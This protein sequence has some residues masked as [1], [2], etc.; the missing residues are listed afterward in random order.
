MSKSREGLEGGLVSPHTPGG[1]DRSPSF[2]RRAKSFAKSACHPGSPKQRIPA[3]EWVP[4]YNLE[5]FQ[6][7]MVAGITV[8]LTVIPQG[9]AYATVAGV[10][11]NYGLYSSFMGCFVYFFFGT[12]KD[13]T[14]GPT[15]IMSIMTHQYITKG[16]ECYEEEGVAEAMAVLLSMITGVVILLATVLRVGFLINFIGRPVI[17]GFTSAAAI[18]IATSQVKSLFG[19]EFEAEGFIE[20]WAEV[21]RHLGETRYQDFLVGAVSCVVL[22]LMR[23]MRNQPWAKVRDGDSAGQLVLKKVI[24]LVSVGRNAI[25][26]L[27]FCG[28]AYAV[29]DLYDTAPFTIVGYI[30][31]GMPVPGLPQFYLD[32]DNGTVHYSLLQVFGQFGTGMVI[33]PLLAILENIAI[34]SAFS[35]GKAIDATQEMLALGLCNLVGSFFHAI[36]T[37]GSFSRTAINSTSGVRT[38]AGGIMTGFIVIMALLFLTPVFGYIPKAALA[39][40]IICAVIFS[41]EYHDVLPIWRTCRWDQLPLWAT[42]LTCLLWGLEYGILLGAF[43]HLCLLL[44]HTATP[45]VTVQRHGEEQRVVVRPALGML[46]PNSEHI[47]RAA[48]SAGVLHTG[49]AVVLDL[50][51]VSVVDYTAALAIQNLCKEFTERGQRLAFANLS[52][53]VK[54]SLEVLVPALLEVPLQVEDEQ[55]EGAAPGAD[56]LVAVTTDP[57]PH[58]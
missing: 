21:F 10:E 7:D 9:I 23:S 11:P 45:S 54:Q 32:C 41:I 5:D 52:P 56:G 3:L 25:V 31:P 51:H 27:F 29:Q 58:V 44:W 6:G 20:T 16:I 12:S 50:N 4:R 34:A 35:H 33:V 46:Y 39:A 1:A 55:V 19:L 22:L 48:A 38:T 57:D 40:V 43:V 15:A 53:R 18:T 14:I 13:I 24:F 42:F 47:K 30:E 49:C 2:A 17:S 28:V 36:P 37:T 8:G 26:V